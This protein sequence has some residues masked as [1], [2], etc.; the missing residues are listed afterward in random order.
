MAGFLKGKD[1]T[2]AQFK[3]VA[4]KH[5]YEIAIE[6]EDERIS[7]GELLERAGA[8]YNSFCQMGIAGKTVAIFTNRCPQTVYAVLAA[9]RAGARCVIMRASGPI[10]KI[11]ETLSV[12][13]PSAA[14][15]H[16]CHLDR[17]TPALLSAGCKSAITVGKTESEMMPSLYTLSELMDINS[18]SIVTPPL[19]EGSVVL[20]NDG[21]RFD[22]SEE[23]KNVP[24]R[25]GIYNSLPLYC[26]AGYDAMWQTLMSGHKCFF[27]DMPSK[28]LFKRKKIALALLYEGDDSFDC[29]AVFYSNP[30]TFCINGEFLYPEECEEAIGNATGY[31]VRCDYEEGKVK[32][33]VTLPPDSDI[34]AVS[35]SPLARAVSGY[36]ADV[37]Y[38]IICRKSVVFK[39]T[40]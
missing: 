2:Y 40:V 31:P 28:A 3:T 22:A 14:I 19:S 4:Y 32:I 35:D 13:R 6:T 36:C 21:V 38:G 7:Y 10:S 9:S 16:A 5:K 8:L 34:S 12:Y 23:I 1:M 27:T 37:F 30:D 26:G 15:L 25:A 39:K 33:T 24:A 20:A 11:K 18:Y 17:L 29:D